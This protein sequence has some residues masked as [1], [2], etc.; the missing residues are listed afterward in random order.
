[1]TT[2]GKSVP[3]TTLVEAILEPSKTIKKGYETLTIM[4]DGGRTISGLLAEDRI[5]AVILRDSGQEGKLITIAKSRI[6]QQSNRG[7]SLMPAG[8]I[9]ALASR[10]QFLDLLRYLMEIA[11]HGPARRGRCDPT[12]L[13]WR[14]RYLLTSGIS[15]IPD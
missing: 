2:L 8:L 9:N 6:E 5:D 11:E 1:M 10:Q 7:P 15:T 14:L 4:T 12:R 3:D 13:Y